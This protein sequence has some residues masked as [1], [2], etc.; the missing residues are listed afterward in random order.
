M[1]EQFFGN[2]PWLW[3]LFSLSILGTAVWR[4]IGV[5]VSGKIRPDSALFNWFYCVAYAMLAGLISRMI[6]L[7][8]AALAETELW[9]RL[10]ALALGMT[11]FFLRG[12]ALLLGCL[13][14]LVS[15]IVLNV[16]F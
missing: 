3:A 2:D 12:R 7:P 13:V 8:E 1:P 5:V 11:V 16:W 4:L 9:H 10:L 15:F 6:I 14:G